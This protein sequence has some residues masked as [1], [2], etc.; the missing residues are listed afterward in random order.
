M[1]NR[2]PLQ[3]NEDHALLG[4]L[5]CLLDSH[6]SLSG[7]ALAHTDPALAVADDHECAAVEPLAALHDLCDPVQVDQF[8]FQAIAFFRLFIVVSFCQSRL[9]L[10][11]FSPWLVAGGKSSS[12]SQELKTLTPAPAPRQQAP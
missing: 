3:G 6:R 4:P 11:C 10:S 2:I 8:I 9:Q 12:M 5:H 7:F 1:G